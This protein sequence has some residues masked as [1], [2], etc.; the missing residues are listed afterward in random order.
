MSDH[1][2]KIKSMKLYTHI[3]RIYGELA[4]LGKGQGALNAAE[5]SE[6]DQMHYH[7]TVSVSHAIDMMGITSGQ[8]VLEIGSGFGGPARHIAAST[9]AHVAAIELQEDQNA[10]AAELTERCGLT[11]KIDH[12][13]GDFL[14]YHFDH[15]TFDHIVSWLALFHI[16]DR[17]Q[18][19]K[20]SHQMLKPDGIFFTEDM[21]SRSPM[22]E[23]EFKEL[24]TGMY[25]SYL[26]EMSQYKTNFEENGF[27][28]V[29]IEEMSDNWTEFTTQRLTDYRQL[30]DRH[31][32]VHGEA[33][34]IALEEFYDLVNRHFRS[35]KL[36][37]LR[38]MARKVA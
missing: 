5:I 17:Y 2:T 29:D 36:G 26:P 3:D 34:Y 10:L 32:R 22:E 21:Y 23:W 30:R 1:A 9:G 14:A 38:V 33:A 4:E 28:I 12:V 37:G 35:G 11:D 18:L 13:C 27:E 20:R 6:I 16:P 31:I 24:A 25:A 7:G 8:S 19:L 15:Q